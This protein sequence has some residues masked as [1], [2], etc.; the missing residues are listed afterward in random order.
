[1]AILDS[2]ELS[3]AIKTGRAVPAWLLYSYDEYLLSSFT[4]R[5]IGS[6]TQETGEDATVLP[7]PI[8]DIGKAVEAAGAISLFGTKRVVLFSHLDPAAVNT[9]DLKLLADLCSEVENAVL[10]FTVL[11]KEPAKTWKGAAALKLP[12]SAKTLLSAVEQCGIVAALEK[13]NEGS[14]KQ[15]VM[16][17]AKELGAEFDENAAETLVER[18]GIDLLLLRAETEKLAAAC[19]YGEINLT[20][21]QKMSTRNIEADVFELSR[22][23]LTGRAD[24]AYRLLGE[25]FYLQNEPIM[26]AAA[27]TGSYLD[28]Y[29]VKAG[30]AA[31]ASYGTVFKELGY[32]GSDYRLKKSL[33]TA[34]NYSLSQ[35]A[36]CL[37]ILARLDKKLKGSAVDRKILLELAVGELLMCG[38]TKRRNY[39]H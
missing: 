25:L 1:M 21:V 27:L 26:I 34:K 16:R 15:Y 20:L 32:K 3:R 19:G 38:D 9:A 11:L 30:A 31:G 39:A 10:V 37:D 23:I 36:E 33:E 18:C 17:Y 24:A 8:P 5:L 2:S 14:A 28:M 6:L 35:L 12:A 7:G 4:S 29:R 22:H 13:P